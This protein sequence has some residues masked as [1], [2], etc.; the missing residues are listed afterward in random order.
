M[1]IY[2]KYQ[3]N[4][5]LLVPDIFSDRKRTTPLFLKTVLF[6]KSQTM[7]INGS[8]SYKVSIRPKE[9]AKTRTRLALWIK[10]TTKTQTK[11]A[12]LNANNSK[13]ID[14]TALFV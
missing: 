12:L 10:L 8:D 4:S 5:K 9:T 2:Q 7:K 14:K 13:D 1:I 3:D 11:L 6:H